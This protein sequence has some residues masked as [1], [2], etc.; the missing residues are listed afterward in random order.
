MNWSKVV[1]Q[2]GKMHGKS[3]VAADKHHDPHYQ[4]LHRDRAA[5]ADALQEALMAGL[6]ESEMAE[7]VKLNGLTEE[8]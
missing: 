4:K 1:F 3:L 6:S 8:G 2:L 5:L 7:L